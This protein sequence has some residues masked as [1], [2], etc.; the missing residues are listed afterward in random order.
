MTVLYASFFGITVSWGISTACVNR[1]SICDGL[2]LVECVRLP[3]AN[4]CM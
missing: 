2:R 4:R 1:P 3:D